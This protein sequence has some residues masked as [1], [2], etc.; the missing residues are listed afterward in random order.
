[1]GF[2]RWGK[3]KSDKQEHRLVIKKSKVQL[4]F[5]SVLFLQITKRK[6]S[7]RSLDLWQLDLIKQKKNLHR[8]IPFCAKNNWLSRQSERWIAP[9]KLIFLWK[10]GFKSSEA[11]LRFQYTN[12]EAD[13]ERSLFQ[14]H[15]ALF[16]FVLHHD[17]GG[18]ERRG[19][20][21]RGDCVRCFGRCFI[22]MHSGIFF[23][24]LL[25]CAAPAPWRDGK[26]PESTQP[27]SASLHPAA[28]ADLL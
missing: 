23:S 1:M 19:G 14:F 3:D 21:G 27:A 2:L 25:Q 12:T 5:C 17:A 26:R 10:W 9:R 6:A 24:C 15:E 20:R 8:K 4:A 28:S 22:L 18:Q 7:H 11:P 13:A 16:E